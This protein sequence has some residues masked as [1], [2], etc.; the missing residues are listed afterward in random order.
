MFS[1]LLV[2]HKSSQY[3]AGMLS[4]SN[5]GLSVITLGDK[6]LCEVTCESKIVQDRRVK[7]PMSIPGGR[8]PDVS[9]NENRFLYQCLVV[10][11]LLSLHL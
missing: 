1:W 5:D 6:F 10:L 2:S 4:Q 8:I 7:V 9:M 11:Q 3:R